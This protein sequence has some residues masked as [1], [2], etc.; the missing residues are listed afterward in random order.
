[1]AVTHCYAMLNLEHSD[2]SWIM[3]AEFQSKDFCS[4]FTI[5]LYFV[6]KKIETISISEPAVGGFIKVLYFYPYIFQCA[7]MTFRSQH[8]SCLYNWV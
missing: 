7:Q 3:G 4:S 8:A 2:T 1:M 6:F 5:S